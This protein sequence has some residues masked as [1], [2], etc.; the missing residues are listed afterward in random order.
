MDYK[1]IAQNILDNVG[2]KENVK[3][4]THCF[5][6]LRFVLKEESKA[7]KEK[8]EQIEG[9]ISVVVAGGQFQV[10]CGAK[11][12]KIYDAVVEVMGGTGTETAEAGKQG[13]GNLILQKITEMFTPLIPAIAAAGLLKGLLTAARL[14]MK[15]QGVDITTS[16]TYVILFAASQVI[17][18]FLPIFLGMTCAKALKTNQVIAMAIAGLL[19]Y[20][21]IDAMIQNVDQANTIFGLPVIK[22]AWKIG[23]SVRVFSYVE[24]VIPIILAVIVLAYLEKALKKIIPEIL[25][26]ILVPGLELIIMIP[27]TLSLLGPIGIYVG[28]GIQFVY[29]A[30]MSFSTVLGGALVG[31]L[32]GVFV[33]FGAHRALLPIG[34]NDVAINGRQNLLA[35]AGAANFS[36]GGA[37]FGVMLKTRDKTLKQVAASGG[38]AATLVGITE[39]A[40]YG[41]NLRLKRP[42]IYAVICGA[43]GGGIMGLGNVYGDAFA[44]NG[45]L[46]IFT[47]AAFG[48]T[49]FVFYLVGIAVAFFGAAAMTYLLGFEDI[50]TEVKKEEAPSVPVD[51]ATAD[52]KITAPVE[53]RAYDLSQVPDEVFASG[54]LGQGIG[55]L[56]SKGEI[57]APADCMV[58]VL[59]PS[60]HALGLDLENGVELLIHIG[61]DTVEMNGEGFK[62][63]VEQGD[64]VKKGTKLVEFDIEKIKAAGHDTTVS[65]VVSNGESFAGVSG[66]PAEKAD[67]ETTVILIKK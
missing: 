36:Q 6:R 54:A 49:Q 63:A 65:I 55:I 60:L 44:N 7:K 66:A 29:D 30:L 56:P 61:M 37:V 13:I 16:D 40:I 50:K 46:T 23:E 25:Q 10:V 9:V 34:L 17:F 58:S 59:Y 41:C 42:M 62:K 31:G 15:Q 67:A 38:I 11:V 18:Y 20:P 48:M 35:F 19:V 26:I 57:I 1:K 28:N 39:P 21:Q 64:K 32:W 47:Y 43:I 4:V 27:L 33:I 2:G 24:S 3:N 53:G 8:V 22:G 14:L 12:T 51:E 5:T 52:I 45:V